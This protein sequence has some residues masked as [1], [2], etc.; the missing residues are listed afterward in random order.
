ME[1]AE[2]SKSSNAGNMAKGVLKDAKFNLIRYANCWEDADL[3]LSAFQGKTNASFCSIASAG[4]NSLSLLT[5][6]PKKVVA[7]DLSSEQLHLTALKIAAFKALSH[8]ELLPFIG[9]TE[10]SLR[11][12][13]FER[14]RK[15]LSIEAAAFWEKNLELIEAG[16]VFGGKFEKY[17]EFFRTKVL[18]FIH[19]QPTIER[20]FDPKSAE[21]QS[22]FYREKWNSWRWK[23]LFKI[24]FS[25]TIMGKFGRD[26]EFLKQVEINVANF[27]YSQAEAQLSSDA[28]FQNYFLEMI[29]L[30]KFGST[31][32]HYLRK[33]HFQTIRKN[34]DTLELREG[35]LE[36]TLENDVFDGFN[37]SNIFEYLPIEVCFSISQQIAAHSTPMATLAYWNLMVPRNLADLD[38]ANWEN[39]QHGIPRKMDKGFFYANFTVNNKR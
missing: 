36:Q 29:M 22:K 31:L 30:G 24:F 28:L 15:E 39:H 20:L 11:A 35:Y 3:L 23:A 8:E 26:P 17:F 25:R 7:V 9:I 5:L 4:D 38:A 1:E 33:E 13:Y 14:I 18:P 37:L 12:S 21:E 16:L 34:I 19:K 27:I 32:P 2:K 10:S 6:N